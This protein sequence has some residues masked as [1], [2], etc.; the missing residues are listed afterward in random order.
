MK[1]VGTRVFE[2]RQR[3]ARGWYRVIYLAVVENT[4][5]VLHSFEKHSRKTPQRDL[6][7]AKARLKNVMARIRERK[8]R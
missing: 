4:I 3:D 1:S 6:E 2:L 8:G 7:V 5:Y